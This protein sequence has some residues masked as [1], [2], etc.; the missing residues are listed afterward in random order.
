M[1][2]RGLSGVLGAIGGVVGP[3]AFI[4]G[5]AGTAI[6]T[7]HYSSLK[8]AISQLAR[9]G[10]P[11][12]WLMSVAFFVFALGLLAL[13]PALSKGLGAPLLRAAITVSAIG[14]LGVAAFPL[15]MKSGGIEDHTHVFWAVVGYAGTIAAPLLAGL[16]LR[17][18]HAAVG[19]ISM[20][21]GTLSFGALVGSGFSNIPGFWQ[22]SGLGIVD[23][24]FI[25]ASIWL[26][27]HPTPNAPVAEA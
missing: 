12:R 16:T 26:L 25:A 23:L 17:R 21:V 19:F 15:N 11:H 14:A 24:W 20:V 6:L 10:A 18:A 9:I 4:S 22:R 3:I 13:A 1:R 5:W 8:E 27:F 2:H 7:P